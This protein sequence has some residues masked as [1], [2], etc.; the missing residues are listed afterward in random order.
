M[1]HRAARINSHKE[2]LSEDVLEALK[3]ARFIAPLRNKEKIRIQVCYSIFM[4][5]GEDLCKVD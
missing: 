2:R 4:P 1:N 5:S 3:V